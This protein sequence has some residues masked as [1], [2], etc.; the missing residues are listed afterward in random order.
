M[1]NPLN[2][3]YRDYKQQNFKGTHGVPKPILDDEF[4]PDYTQVRACPKC[5]SFNV[6][7]DAATN[8]TICRD[9]KEPTDNPDRIDFQREM[10]K[11][12]EEAIQ[13]YEEATKRGVIFDRR[14]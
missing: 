2:Q 6:S 7:V 10:E 1:E 9:C 5:G 8:K 3:I 13:R 4:E 14:P 11:H 12:R